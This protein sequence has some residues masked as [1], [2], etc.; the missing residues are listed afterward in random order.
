MDEEQSKLAS[1]MA[2]ELYI[3]FASY[4]LCFLMYVVTR[5]S[6]DGIAKWYLMSAD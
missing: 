5:I 4:I 1:I 6:C 3:F 2:V